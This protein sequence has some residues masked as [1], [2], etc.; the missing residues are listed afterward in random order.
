M[1]TWE[2]P[3]SELSIT[4][5]DPRFGTSLGLSTLCP[6]ELP[7]EIIEQPFAW[8]DVLMSHGE[9][10]IATLAY[11]S[12]AIPESRRKV[13]QR[14]RTISFPHTQFTTPLHIVL[15]QRRNIVTTR[16]LPMDRWGTE[17]VENTLAYIPFALQSTSV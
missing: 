1:P 9:R 11:G 8:F 14:T 7:L 10:E 16:S 2:E 3:R 13:E 12:T 6:T 4:L 15:R 17:L 5:T